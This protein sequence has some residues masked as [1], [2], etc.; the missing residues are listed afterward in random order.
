MATTAAAK[1][2]STGGVQPQQ[3]VSWRRPIEAEQVVV[4]RRVIS[5]GYNTRS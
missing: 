1:A 5:C 3:S 4:L 2:K